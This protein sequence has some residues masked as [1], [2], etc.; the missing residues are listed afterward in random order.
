MRPGGPPRQ[1]AALF[2]ALA[3]GNDRRG[4]ILSKVKVEADVDIVGG[5]V[6]VEAEIVEG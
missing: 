4:C 3:D 5:G 1:G 2:S 6:V